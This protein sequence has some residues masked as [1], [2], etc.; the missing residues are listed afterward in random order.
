MVLAA[1]A[2][3]VHRSARVTTPVRLTREFHLSSLV[4][5]KPIA[6]ASAELGTRREHRRRDLPD[7]TQSKIAISTSG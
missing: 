3:S 2:A 1:S 5:V 4:S 7:R 6:F